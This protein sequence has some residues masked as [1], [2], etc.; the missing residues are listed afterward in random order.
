M[1]L[2]ALYIGGLVFWIFTAAVA[3]AI[4]TT[5]FADSD[6]EGWPL[7]ILCFAVVAF[8]LLFGHEFAPPYNELQWRLF[9][10]GSYLPIGILWSMFKTWK[11]ARESRDE[12]RIQK[13]YWKPPTYGPKTWNDY[14]DQQM[15]KVTQMKAQL[16][17]WIFDWP[18]SMV[19]Y[20]ASDL[21]EDALRAI[22]T[23]IYNFFGGI[24]RRIIDSFSRSIKD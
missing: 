13:A 24:Y 18:L 16:L 10:V 15:P 6:G 12:L 4:I 14:V 1:I 17:T 8:T 2:D 9:F 22:G 7:G 3:F 23:A 21:I 20:V 5:Y 19:W 11:L